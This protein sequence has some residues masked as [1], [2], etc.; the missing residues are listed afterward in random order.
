MISNNLECKL[1]DHS[2][3]VSGCY[4]VCSGND[5]THVYGRSKDDGN[6]T[7]LIADSFRPHVTSCILD[8]EMVGF[9]ADTKT[10]GTGLCLSVCLSLCNTVC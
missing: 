1:L 7:P 5:Y 8:G 9:N 2:I 3:H 10:I 6:F 4:Y